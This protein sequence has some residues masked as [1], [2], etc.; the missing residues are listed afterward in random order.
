[1]YALVHV[2]KTGG[3]SIKKSI[4]N[5]CRGMHRPV[6]WFDNHDHDHTFMTMVRDPYDTAAS[7]YFFTKRQGIKQGST[8]FDIY[9]KNL[10]WKEN[11]DVN[12][13][14]EKTVPNHRYAYYF[15]TKS[16]EDFDYVGYTYDMKASVELANKMFDM[17]IYYRAVNTN[18]SHTLG[19]EYNLGYS[20]QAFKE[21]HSKDY[22]IYNAGVER[23]LYLCQT[24]NIPTSLIQ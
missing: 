18:P 22:D 19:N 23:F 17:N 12:T 2:P 24:Y 7:G 21:R 13:F 20:R 3:T 4:P 14:L 16:I 8:D 1:M 9:H 5:L 6:S 15:D 11:V 10:I